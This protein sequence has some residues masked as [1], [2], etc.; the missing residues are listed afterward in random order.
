MK[1]L[2]SVF[3][4]LLAIVMVLALAA[5]GG[6]DTPATPATPTE[7]TEPAEP[8]QPA[9]PA[10]PAAP[11]ITGQPKSQTAAEDA[12][13]KF[14]VKATGDDLTYQ[15]YYRTSSSGEWKTST[16]DTANAATLKVKDLASRN[17]H[18]Y[19]CEVSN[20]AGHTYSEIVTLK[21]G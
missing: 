20:A 2:K 7:P 5:C 13:V 17:G 15:W 4:L 18:Q 10:D 3:A 8:T 1:T 11:A 19:M 9:E 14:T 6:K 16:L 21:V 12:L